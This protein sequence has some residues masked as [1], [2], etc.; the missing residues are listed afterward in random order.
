[1]DFGIQLLVV[2]GAVA[3]VRAMGV[4][5][6]L[7][8]GMPFVVLALIFYGIVTPI[9]VVM[10]LFGRDKLTR[11]FDAEATSYWVAHD[12]GGE[13]ARYLRQS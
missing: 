5:L 6:G 4:P 13:P 8:D 11:R 3:S 7:A 1:M 2:G 9:G 12:P 10:R